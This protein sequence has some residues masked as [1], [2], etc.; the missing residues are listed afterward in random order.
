[1]H[2]KYDQPRPRLDGILLFR[3]VSGL[4]LDAISE[5]CFWQ[6]FSSGTQILSSDDLNT[7]VFFVIEGAVLARAFSEEGK[8]VFYSDIG[9]GQFFGEFAAIDGK[10]R[11]ASIDAIEDCHI[12][13]MT[14][15]QFR[16]ILL[17][18]AILGLRMTELLVAK[19]RVLSQRIFEYG[20]LTVR[21]RIQRELVRLCEPVADGTNQVVIDPAPTHYEI[22]TRIATHR[23]AVSRELNQL[24]ACKIIEIDRRRIKV[25]DL[26]RLRQFNQSSRK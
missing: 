10:P 25:L 23:E 3:G 17:E 2:G 20:T 12:A 26:H 14:S 22:A 19:T 11:S 15:E 21:E 7:D 13:R 9:A 1:M 8:E 6:R 16:K 18:N 4:D 5:A 24:A